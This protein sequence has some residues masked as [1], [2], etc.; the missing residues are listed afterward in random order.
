MLQEL[1]L[2][3]VNYFGMNKI[4]LEVIWIRRRLTSVLDLEKREVSK[5]SKL[6]QITTSRTVAMDANLDSKG[7]YC[8]INLF[9]AGMLNF[10][11][12]LLKFS[13]RNGLVYVSALC[14]TYLWTIYQR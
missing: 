2:N 3:W 8:L 14:W 5:S 12:F 6:G 9:A 10:S 1:D 4:W 11:W 13:N 7:S